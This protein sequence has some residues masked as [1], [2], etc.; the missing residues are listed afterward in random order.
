MEIKTM[1]DA[2]TEAETVAISLGDTLQALNVLTEAM[3]DEG[4]QGDVEP[5]QAIA[6]ARR[7]PMFCATARVLCRELD[8]IGKLTREVS[9]GMYAVCKRQA[10]AKGDA[11]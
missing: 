5:W 11:E 7:Y 6:L 3:E 2:A 1:I 4:I 8:R 10:A 9:E